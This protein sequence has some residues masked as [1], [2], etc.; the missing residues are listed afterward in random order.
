MAQNNTNPTIHGSLSQKRLWHFS[1]Q[2][3]PTPGRSQVPD[4]IDAPPKIPRARVLGSIPETLDHF[5]ELLDPLLPML[6][7]LLSFGDHFLRST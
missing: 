3:S 7:A 5:L 6:L 4:L 2:I 1:L